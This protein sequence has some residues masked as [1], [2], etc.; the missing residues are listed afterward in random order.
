MTMS[1]V[2]HAIVATSGFGLT[3]RRMGALFGWVWVWVGFGVGF[4]FGFGFGLVGW[5][6]GCAYN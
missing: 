5:L 4:G 3:D 6:V 2:G 1:M